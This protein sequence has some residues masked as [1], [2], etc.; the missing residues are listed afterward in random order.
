MPKPQEL[1]TTF[2][3]GQKLIKDLSSAYQWMLLDEESC[4]LVT[5]NT[6]LWLF[7]NCRFP[8][9][10]ASAQAIFQ[11]AIDVLLQGIHMLFTALMMY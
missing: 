5:V 9:R 7:T 1:S 2:P 3:G 10:I 4:K 6:H 8:F 11:H